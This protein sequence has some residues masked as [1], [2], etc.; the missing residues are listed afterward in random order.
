VSREGGGPASLPYTIFRIFFL[1]FEGLLLEF[2]G[3][4]SGK[5]GHGPASKNKKF[6]HGGK[7]EKRHELNQCQ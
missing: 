3:I 2:K 6:L 4:R 7:D 1:L 5:L